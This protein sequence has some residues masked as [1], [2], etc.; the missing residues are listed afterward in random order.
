M[1]SCLFVQ[2]CTSFSSKIT[3]TKKVVV[4]SGLKRLEL[5]KGNRSYVVAPFTKV[6]ETT[7]T[8]RY[9]ISMKTEAWV[10]L[11]KTEEIKPG[12][13]KP[14]FVAGQSLLVV[15][16]YDGQVYCTA[17]VCP[18]LGTPLD[19]GLIGSGTLICAQ[20]RTSWRLSDGK[21][22]GKWCPYP[23]IL[24]PLLGKLKVPQDLSVFPVREMNGFIEALIDLDAAKEFESNYWR[25]ILDAQG[26][27]TGGYY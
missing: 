25:G 10:K 24:G 12:D 23:P 3:Y 26:K 17:N 27:A 14:F 6:G 1:K 9:S 20:H 7:N 18:H 15:C 8:P 2:P 11:V 21:L 5:W 22:A 16:D 13:L 19:Q 4:S